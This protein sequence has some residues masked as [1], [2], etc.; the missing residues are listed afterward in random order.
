MRPCS[1][2][3]SRYILYSISEAS[4]SCVEYNRTY[5]RYKL[6]SPIAEVERLAFKA[7]DLREQAL[8]A[9]RKALR[10]RKQARVLYKKM[11]DL[12]TRE[13]QN[14]LNLETEEALKGAFSG[15]ASELPSSLSA[16]A[17]GFSPGLVGFS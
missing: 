15:S 8:E 11:R 14:I 3:V 17:P 5:R 7:E 12:G 6:A 4:D 16:P 10:L 1:A 13:E 9:E 2:C